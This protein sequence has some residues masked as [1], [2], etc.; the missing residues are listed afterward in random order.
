VYWIAVGLLVL[1][2]VSGILSFALLGQSA[3]APFPAMTLVH[4]AI[5]GYVVLRESYTRLMFCSTVL[6]V[7][8]VS[9]SMLFANLAPQTFTFDAVMRLLFRPWK[10]AALVAVCAVM[11]AWHAAVFRE[12]RGAGVGPPGSRG[13]VSA[14]LY[15]SIAGGINGSATAMLCKIPIELGKSDIAGDEPDDRPAWSRWQ[16]LACLALVPLSAAGQLWHMNEG[17]KYYDSVLWVPLYQATLLVGGVLTGYIWWDDWRLYTEES[18]CHFL[19]GLGVTLVGM[20]MLAAGYTENSRQNLKSDQC[21]LC[22]LTRADRVRIRKERGEAEERAER[23]VDAVELDSARGSRCGE[24][25]AWGF[26]VVAAIAGGAAARLHFLS[27]RT[28]GEIR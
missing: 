26:L 3:Q 12:A 23:D 11:V 6:I 18:N 10:V 27:A 7:G 1:S 14:L 17:L 16:T 20:V 24:T 13:G 9:Y 15:Y 19:A 21:S 28:A 8:G 22:P 25:T 2:A 4:N 5:L